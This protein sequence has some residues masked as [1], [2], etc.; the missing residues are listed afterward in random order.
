MIRI[1][2]VD[3]LEKVTKNPDFFHF[4]SHGMPWH[5]RQES[6]KKAENQMLLCIQDN[7]SMYFSNLSLI[8]NNKTINYIT[9]QLILGV[10]TPGKKCSLD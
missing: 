3:L 9:D 8:F 4:I 1:E 10:M 6:A 2:L 7:L 5:W